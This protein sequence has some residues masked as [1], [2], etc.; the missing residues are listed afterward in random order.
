MLIVEV[1]LQ[2]QAD[3]LKLVP[4]QSGRE[5]RHKGENAAREGR[6]SHVCS[7]RCTASKGAKQ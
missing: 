7:Q 2:D 1:S 6:Q 5:V 3:Q 4:V